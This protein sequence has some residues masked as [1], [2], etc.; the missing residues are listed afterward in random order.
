MA[1][2]SRSAQHVHQSDDGSKRLIKADPL[3]GRANDTWRTKSSYSAAHN[4]SLRSDR[5]YWQSVW[6]GRTKQLL[7]LP[8][9]IGGCRLEHQHRE[10]WHRLDGALE[11]REIVRCRISVASSPIAPRCRV[12]TRQVSALSLSAA[13]STGSM[14]GNASTSGGWCCAIAISDWIGR[15]MGGRADA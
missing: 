3:I 9:G 7:P 6:P 4:M 1:I 8:A 12:R 5:P 14:Q 15:A 11:R 2:A 10:G 13:V